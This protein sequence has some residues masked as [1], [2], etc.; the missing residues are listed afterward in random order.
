MQE[1]F[2]NAV[3]ALNKNVEGAS[4]VVIFVVEGNDAVLMAD[5]GHS[6]WYIERV[7]RIPYPKGATW[8]TILE[9]KP[10]YVPDTDEDNALGPAGK[11]FG[12]KSYLSMPIQSDEKTVGCIHIHSAGKEPVLLQKTSTCSRS[13]PGSW[14][15][16][17]RT[18]DKPRR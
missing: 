11:E 18:Q 6:D 2:E 15:R 8:K 9:G 14:N 16:P 5:R 10:R 12:T 1:V 13:W 4:N 17:L 3:D 7:R